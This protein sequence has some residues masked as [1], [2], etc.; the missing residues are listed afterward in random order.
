MSGQGARL[1]SFAQRVMSKVDAWYNRRH[2]LQPVG[3]VLLIGRVRYQGPEL[4]FPD[5]TLLRTDDL[6]GQLHFSNHSISALGAG[7]TQLT[8]FRFAR[9]MR[10]SL[11]LLAHTAQSDPALST[12]SVFRGVTWLP[13]HGDVVGFISE[14]LP[15][16]VRNWWLG[17]YFRL[18]TW[19][20]SPA[21]RGRRERRSP[22]PRVYWLTRSM[23]EQNLSKL[24]KGA[25]RGVAG[26][27]ERAL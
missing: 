27:A 3:Q 9:L 7:G 13:A 18:L 11:R 4:S 16:T 19:V 24:S 23:L 6:I 8:G 15:R 20:F 12:I 21:V 10:E 5:G 17:P 25:G 1:R 22:A 14:P 26:S 2:G